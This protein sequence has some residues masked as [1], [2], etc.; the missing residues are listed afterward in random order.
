MQT[1][2]QATQN[3]R[4]LVSSHQESKCDSNSQAEGILQRLFDLMSATYGHKFTSRYTWDD[5]D[6][7][8]YALRG[9]RPEQ[10]KEAV[11]KLRD[12]YPEWPPEPNEFYLLCLG[13]DKPQKDDDGNDATWQHKRIERADK[14]YN[15]L[16]IEHV[17][18][19]QEVAKQHLSDI[20]ALL[21]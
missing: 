6:A 18:T 19:N 4:Q 8:G 16:Q 20:K 7:W 13:R 1:I 9:V 10:I 14:E 3:L 2:D 15:A 17:K 21:V 11:E 12:E 5:R